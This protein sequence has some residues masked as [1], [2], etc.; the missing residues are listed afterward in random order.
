M[1]QLDVGQRALVGCA[2]IRVDDLFALR[3][4]H[5]ERS[6]RLH[7]ADCLRGARPLTEQ[8]DQLAVQLI[9]SESQFFD[10]IASSNG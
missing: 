6:G 7:V 4:V 1:R 10:V 2:H 3:L 9:D 8:L 5:R